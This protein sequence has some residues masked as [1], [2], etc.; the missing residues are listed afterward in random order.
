MH[1][2]I[3]RSGC[4]FLS[5]LQTTEA[6][7]YIFFF[8]SFVGRTQR[9]RQQPVHDDVRVAPDGRCEV[10]VEGNVE[11][12]V[13]KMFPLQPRTGTEVQ[14]QLRTQTAHIITA[15]SFLSVMLMVMEPCWRNVHSEQKHLMKYSFHK[16][17]F[18]PFKISVSLKKKRY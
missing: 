5:L 18:L 4:V 17:F 10:C 11:S 9:R 2:V 7:F 13:L 8:A 14:G 1:R 12:V 15:S 3:W 6:A 16:M